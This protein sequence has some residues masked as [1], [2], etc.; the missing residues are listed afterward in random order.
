MNKAYTEL[1][2]ESKQFFVIFSISGICLFLHGPYAKVIQ[3]NDIVILNTTIV[4]CWNQTHLFLYQSKKLHWIFKNVFFFLSCR[5]RVR[6]LW[7]QPRRDDRLL[8]HARRHHRGHHHLRRGLNI[9]NHFLKPIDK[10]GY[11]ISQ[12]V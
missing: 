4:L 7:H 1:K 8:H 5:Q 9:T 10:K 2:K 12:F 6:R 3:F 11:T